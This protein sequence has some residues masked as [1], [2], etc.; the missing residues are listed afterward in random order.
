MLTAEMP[1]CA[2]ALC[3]SEML[4][5]LM[6]PFPFLMSVLLLAW[7]EGPGKVTPCHDQIN[8]LLEDVLRWGIRRSC[9]MIASRHW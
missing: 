7:R 2:A 4:I 9:A 6:D 8:D 5:A 1:P 3:L